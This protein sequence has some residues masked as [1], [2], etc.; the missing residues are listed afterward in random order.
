MKTMTRRDVLKNMGL[1]ALSSLAFSTKMM[2][3]NHS[4]MKEKADGKKLVAYF[5]WGGNT[6]KLAEEIASQTG[7]DIYRIETVNEYPKEY[8]PCTEVALKEK[9]EN[10][11]PEMKNPLKNLND[12]D[13]IFVGCPVWWW[14]TPMVIHSFFEDS[15]YNFKGKTIIP[16]VTYEATYR[17]E[18]LAKIVEL[19]PDSSH[20]KGFGT[21]GDLSGVKT[22]LQEIGMTK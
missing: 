12:Y 2:G 17:D 5:S 1:L 7:A 8:R 21:T 20:L 15:E 4:S 11:H 14:T 13:V 3:N 10:V 16:F 9:N 19:S 22:W 6:K 18:T